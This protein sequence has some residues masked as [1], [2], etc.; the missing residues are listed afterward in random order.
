MITF[1]TNVAGSADTPASSTALPVLVGKGMIFASKRFIQRVEQMYLAQPE[2]QSLQVDGTYQMTTNGYALIIIATTSI[3]MGSSDITHTSMPLLLGYGPSENIDFV[4]A[5]VKVLRL[6]ALLFF[7]ISLVIKTATMDHS[8]GLRGGILKENTD[9]TTIFDCFTHIMRAVR[10]KKFVNRDNIEIIIGILTILSTST[11]SAIFKDAS[12]VAMVYIRDCLKEPQFVDDFSKTY[13]G[14]FGVWYHGGTTINGFDISNNTL[15]NCNREVKQLEPN[16]VSISTAM[17]A[18][19]PQLCEK[20]C[21]RKGGLQDVYHRD[22][23]LAKQ[24]QFICSGNFPEFVKEKALKMQQ[25][26][27]STCQYIHDITTLP[28]SPPVTAAVAS[29]THTTTV[30]EASPPITTNASGNLPSRT[31]VYIVNS[32]SCSGTPMSAV[33][34]KQYQDAKREGFGDNEQPTWSECQNWLFSAH[35]VS[36]F[37]DGCYTCDCKAFKKSACICAHVLFVLDDTTA[38]STCKLATIFR[39][40]VVNKPKGRPKTSSANKG[41]PKKLISLEQ[42]SI[43]VLNGAKYITQRVMTA[44]GIYNACGIV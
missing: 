11:S 28:H 23:L 34:A 16:T 24:R 22:D 4:H 19:M 21:L 15:E 2:G 40:L 3:N 20:L 5:M 9:N 43:D 18:V 31:A 41:A 38:D 10:G 36:L 30:S 27:K 14:N 33:R 35:E 44:E 17:S 6:V 39:P 42:S 25:A 12:A 26:Q 29:S 7:D 8:T 37:H 13:L 1:G 32:S